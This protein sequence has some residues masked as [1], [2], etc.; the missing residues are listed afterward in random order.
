MP[1]SDGEEAPGQ[2]TDVVDETIGGLS[3]DER[4]MLHSAVVVSNSDELVTSL[5]HRLRAGELQLET[6]RRHRQ[7]IERDHG[8][9]KVL[10]ARLSA[11]DDH[12]PAACAGGG[13]GAPASS[14]VAQLSDLRRKADTVRES[15]EKLTSGIADMKLRVS[16]ANTE[17][18]GYVRSQTRAIFE[19]LCPSMEV[20]IECDDAAQLGDRSARFRVRGKGRQGDTWRNGVQELSGGQRTLLNLALLLSIAQHRPSMLLLMDEVDAALDDV[21]ASRVADLLKELSHRSQVIAISHRPEFHRVA[22]HTVKLRKHK[23]HTVVS[24]S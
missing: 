11:F 18:V 23:E 22:D 21:N 10:R 19:G 8:T 5:N 3:E 13:T 7:E 6:W 1:A 17:A 16:E 20:D 4:R 15:I 14:R 9:H 12:T 24:N 2:G